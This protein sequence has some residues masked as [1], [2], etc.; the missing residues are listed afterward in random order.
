[1][2][3]V[4]Q[5]VKK[6]PIPAAG[7]ALG[8][9]ALGNLLQPVSGIA[10]V[11]CGMLA[12]TMVALV[13]AKAVMFPRMM[14]EDFR[15]PILASVSATLL[16]ALMQLSGYVAPHAYAPALALWVAAVLGHL[17][18]MAWFTGRFVR[19]FKLDQV[20]PTYFIC[21]VGI[22]VA[23]VTS[24]TYGLEVLGGVLFWVGFACYPILL[25][26]VSYRCLKHPMPDA[27]RPLLCIYAAP[28]SLSIVGYLAVTP[29][30]N[31]AFVAVLLMFAQA[32]F[33]IVALRLPRLIAAGFFPSFAAMT[34]PFVITATALASA[35]ELFADAGIALSPLTAWVAAA[36][37]AFAAIM[38]GFVLIRYAAFLLK[39]VAKAHDAIPEE[40]QVRASL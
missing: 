5:I 14:Q 28:A 35:L 37:T 27:A 24:P 40:R 21:Y 23:A 22:I 34:F 38:V 29:D 8:L 6:V 19:N 9:A 20:F 33:L 12:L 15:N 10:H 18:L 16:M 13:V 4:T 17:A 11:L 1:M 36:E 2:P 32:F 26:V 39:P 31:V 3:A 7:V 30:P 25:T